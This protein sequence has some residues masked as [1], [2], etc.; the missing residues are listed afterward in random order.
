MVAGPA[1]GPALLRALLV[2]GLSAGLAAGAL[3]FVFAHTFGEPQ[4]RHAIAF[5]RQRAVAAGQA[6]EAEVVSREIQS[7]VG[8]G[9]GVV[10]YGTAF[11]GLFALAF[12]LVNGRLGAVGVRALAGLLAL[13]GFVALY[14]VP[15]LKYPAAPPAV[16]DPATIGHRS[17][18]YFGM[19]GLSAAGAVGAV[20][21]G[22]GL[23]PRLGGWD[24]TLAAIGAYAAAMLVAGLL[25][26]GVDEVPTTFPA[27]VLW[28][29]RVAAVGTQVVLWGTLGLVFGA[30]SARAAEARP[31]S[32]GVL[33]A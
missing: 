2:R 24:A 20:R 31:S 5:E 16:G 27:T 17:L 7:T 8:L 21:L 9:L 32:V 3:A 18:L 29:F 19:L 14:L 30:W 23:R 4:I 12:A 10:V 6:P 15:F 13:G 22:R 26:P 11:G 33:V 28:W 25:L 1:D